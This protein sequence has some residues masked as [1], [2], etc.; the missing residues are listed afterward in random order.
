MS[1]SSLLGPF[2]FCTAFCA[3]LFDDASASNRQGIFSLV[4]NTYHNA[5]EVPIDSVAVDSQLKCVARCI[6]SQ[7]CVSGF[8]KVN[9]FGANCFLYKAVFGVNYQTAEVGSVYFYSKGESVH[10]T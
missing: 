6:G 7:C 10:V 1:P 5:T 4:H 3:L 8:W 9:S 2:L